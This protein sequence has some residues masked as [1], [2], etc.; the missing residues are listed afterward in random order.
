MA[1][2]NTAAAPAM[3]P[4]VQ[5]KKT[6]IAPSERFTHLVVREMNG[7][8][9]GDLQLTDF[10]RRLIKNYFIGVDR[11][12]RV[13]EDNRLRKS[14]KYRDEVP[15][16]WENINMNQLAIDVVHYSRLGLD[17]CQK[18]NLHI[19]PYKNKK[20][21]IYDINFMPGYVGLEL[22]TKKY[23]QEIPVDVTTELVYSTDHFKIIKKSGTVP[24]DT[25][26]FEIK[27]AFDRGEIK[28]GFAYIQYE[29]PR[30][31][32]LIHM[33]IADIL[34][35]KNSGQGNAEFWGGDKDKWEDGKKV[36]KEH[37][38]GWFEEMCLKTIK[39]HVYNGSNI[40]LDPRLIDDTYKYIKQREMEAERQLA[41]DEVD[42]NANRVPIDLTPM[43]EDPIDGDS[44]AGDPEEEENPVP[45]AEAHAD[46]EPE[47][48]AQAKQTKRDPGF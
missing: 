37:I 15:V 8:V 22:V 43:D 28:G 3:A 6:D 2:T 1:N 41:Q 23:A 19:I 44:P 25:Y 27:D 33:K 32:K 4:A 14:E 46:P 21:G 40:P 26:E 29:D 5:P 13:A 48:P 20:R 16:T 38:E 7:T 30:K 12:L 47:K 45:T 9:G 11:A 35:R 31:N 24:Y 42:A 18:N 39:R 34:K 17:P 10:Q 36:G